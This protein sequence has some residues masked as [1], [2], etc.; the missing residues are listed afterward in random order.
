MLANDF[1]GEEADP[2]EGWE[3]WSAGRCQMKFPGENQH[4]LGYC[5]WARAFQ[6][7]LNLKMMVIHS[8]NPFIWLFDNLSD[9]VHSSLVIAFA[10]VC[11]I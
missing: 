9:N 3:I 10:F 5:N 7:Y 6:T 4:P 11:L 2:D 1:L 8:Y